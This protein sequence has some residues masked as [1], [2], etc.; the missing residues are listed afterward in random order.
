MGIQF[1]WFFDV[2]VV[3]LLL[4]FLYIGGKRGFI[5][6]VI[7]I[8]GYIISFILAFFISSTASPM[9]YEKYV[10][11]NVVTMVEHNI[12]NIDIAG[13]VQKS[14]GLESMG[15]TVDKQEINDVIAKSNGDLSGDIRNYISK[16]TNGYDVPKAEIDSKLQSIFNSSV[17]DR[18]INSLPSYMT[19]T[20]KEYL[21]KGNQTISET[22]KAFTSTKTDAAK[23]VEK[24]IIRGSV[25]AIIKLLVFIIVFA[26][27]LIIVKLISRVFSLAN[28][29]PI[30]GTINALLGSALGLLQAIAII[31]IIAI[32]LHILIALSNDEMIIFNTQ[33]I[34]KTYLFKLFYDFKLIN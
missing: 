25:I 26:V 3:A 4:A 10:Q 19:D 31:L 29:I 30:A 32:I 16:K 8:A 12:N 1:A 27:A 7:M 24:N 20:A 15:I 11:K 14:L 28:K 17:A 23:F 33:T 2:V 34:Q 18:F 5:R 6:S 9:I 13:E 22:L 21:S